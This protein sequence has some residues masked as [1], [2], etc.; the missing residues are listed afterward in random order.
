MFIERILNKYRKRAEK[1]IHTDPYSMVEDVWQLSFFTADKIGRK[2][3]IPKDDPRRIQGALVTAVKH[4]AEAGHLFATQEEAVAGT[5][6]M[7]GACQKC[8]RDP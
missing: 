4:F 3:G 7:T 6:K 1:I 5:A 2:L 8:R